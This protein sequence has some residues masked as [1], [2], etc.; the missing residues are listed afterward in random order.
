MNKSVKVV[1][2]LG[3]VLIGALSFM[4]LQSNRK[5]SDSSNSANGKQQHKANQKTKKPVVDK[6][7]A[8]IASDPLSIDRENKEENGPE[9][10]PEETE[11]K[12]PWGNT[13]VVSADATPQ[14]KAFAEIVRSEKGLSRLSAIGDVETFD[15][16]RYQK[17]AGYRKAYLSRPVGARVFAP[18]QP[19][20]AVS[21]IKRTSPRYVRLIQGETAI[22]KVKSVPSMP[23]TFSSFDLGRFQKSQL[24]TVTVEADEKGVA[25]ATFESPQGSAGD[26]T[27]VAASP[28]ATGQVRF[29]VN[30]SLPTSAF[31]R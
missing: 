29:L 22:L 11:I 25:T 20:S 26:I 31:T 5:T 4:L 16:G 19:G 18:A 12:N 21:H 23:V 8:K 17:D 2:V 6:S 13:P 27:V 3:L 30:I 1:V 28:V 9:E 24:T 14:T 10:D 15:A 7:K